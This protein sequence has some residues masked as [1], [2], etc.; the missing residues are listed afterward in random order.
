VNV[1]RIPFWLTLLVMASVI[2]AVGQRAY[3]LHEAQ[4][5]FS[6]LFLAVTAIALPALWWIYRES[7]WGYIVALAAIGLPAVHNPLD[8]LRPVAS[9]HAH[10]W[11]TLS[12]DQAFQATEF[13]AV[14][15]VLLVIAIIIGARR[16]AWGAR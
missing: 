9:T 4:S 3:E 5:A 7:L 15:W 2:G 16:G 1:R 10:R 11:M 14:A 12:A 13:V 6:T 8:I